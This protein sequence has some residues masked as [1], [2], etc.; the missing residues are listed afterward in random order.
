MDSKPISDNINHHV[1]VIIPTYNGARKINNILDSLEQQS[2]RDFETIVIID[3]STDNTLEAIHKKKRVLDL[4]IISQDNQ[5]RARVRNKGAENA[6]GDLLI[7]FDDDMRPIPE[8]VEMYLQHY[9]NQKEKIVTGAQ[10]EDFDWVSND[11]Q[12]FKATMSRKWSEKLEKGGNPL[13]FDKLHL[14]AANFSVQKKTFEKLNGF[15]SELKDLEDIDFAIRAYN[16]KIEIHYDPKIIGWHDDYINCRSYIL[17]RREYEK[18]ALK[19][20]LL[21]HDFKYNSTQRKFM[22]KKWIYLIF[23]TKFWVHL[24]DSDKEL[25]ILPQKIRFKVYTLV[26]W[27]LSKYFPNKKI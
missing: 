7:F 18:A 3:G 20:S 8:A 24:I 22:F 14:T 19:L 2:Y 21:N 5:G 17:R 23:S 25:K 13:P 9:S 12:F 1:S 15:N 4:R 11:I 16:L 10:I 27:G 6:K 26:I